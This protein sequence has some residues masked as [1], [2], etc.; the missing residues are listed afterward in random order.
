MYLKTISFT[1]LLRGLSTPGGGEGLGIPKQLGQWLWKVPGGPHSSR[2]ER[3]GIN[4]WPQFM[5]KTKV[6]LVYLSRCRTQ[7]P[8]IQ[9]SYFQMCHPSHPVFSLSHFNWIL[10]RS[11]LVKCYALGVKCNTRTEL[12]DQ[13]SEGDSKP[14][15]KP[16][17]GW[18]CNSVIGTTCSFL[19][20]GQ[21]DACV[22]QRC[23]FLTQPSL[24]CGQ[25]LGSLNQ[26]QWMPRWKRE[27]NCFH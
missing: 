5:K 6:T 15:W 26:S 25:A 14:N 12:V 21:E 8:G 18:V 1:R 10:I 22:E 24:R 9:T 4:I 13:A 27:H 20:S 19:P 17:L 23:S 11:Y 16:R 2:L 7:S 3:S